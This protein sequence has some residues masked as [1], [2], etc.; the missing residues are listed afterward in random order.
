MHVN[1]M[2]RAGKRESKANEGRR[3]GGWD[4]DE[5]EHNDGESSRLGEICLSIIAHP[6]VSKA[7]LSDK[8]SAIRE[9]QVRNRPNRNIG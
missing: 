4:V 1:A 7:E 8:Q 3:K 9:T 2:G 6:Y 5:N